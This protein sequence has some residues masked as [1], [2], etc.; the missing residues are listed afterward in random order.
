MAGRPRQFDEKEVL[1]QVVGVFWAKGFDGTSLSNLFEKVSI[2]RQSLYN[3]FG[4]KEEVFVRALQHY[5]EHMMSPNLAPLN[6]PDADIEA[7]E[8]YLEAVSTVTTI[9]GAD[10]VGC[11]AVNTVIE[12]EDPESPAAKEATRIIRALQSSLLNA[13]KGAERANQLRRGLN[14][15]EAAEYLVTTANG[16]IVQSK[17][18]SSRKQM[19]N[20]AQLALN[21]IRK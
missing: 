12:S 20:T 15:R 7:I 14:L 3:V 6:A 13:L 8:G 17:A 11:L 10:R 18:G 19:R 5:F 21:A 2:P 16:M 9:R 1:D 4:S